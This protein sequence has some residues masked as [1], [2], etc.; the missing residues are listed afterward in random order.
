MAGKKKVIR[1]LVCLVDM[2]SNSKR[3]RPIFLLTCRVEDVEKSDLV[4]NNALLPV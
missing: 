4:V 1:D 2:D 3:Y